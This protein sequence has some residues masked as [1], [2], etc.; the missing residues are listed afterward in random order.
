MD[1]KCSIA[2]PAIANECGIF[3]LLD[4]AKFKQTPYLA[5]LKPGKYVAKDMFEA[6]RRS[7]DARNASTT[8]AIYG[9]GMGEKVALITDGRFFGAGGFCVGH[10]GPEAYV[11][12]M[13]GLL[14]D[15]DKII[16]DAENGSINVELDD[17]EIEKEKRFGR[18]KSQISEAELFGNMLKAVAHKIRKHILEHLKRKMLRRYLNE[19]KTDH[20]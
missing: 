13:I 16:I 7:W 17:N 15:G 1:Q 2:L 12:G 18:R 4:V 10:V 19:S 6:S 11:G 14:N 3:D 8:A 5:D 20:Q 9:Q